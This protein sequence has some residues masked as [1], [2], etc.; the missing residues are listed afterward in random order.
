MVNTSED[1]V[2]SNSS[3]IIASLAVLKA[4]W[5]ELGHDYIENFLPF[6]AETIREAQSPQISLPDIQNTVVRRFGLRIPQGALKTILGRCVKR[7]FIKPQNRIY[8]RDG[9]ALESLSFVL[10]QADAVRKHTALED[11]FVNFCK[12]KYK[13]EWT[14]E[15]ANTAL[16]E[17]LQD[18]S[19]SILAAAIQGSP[20]VATTQ[21][22]KNSDFLVNSFIRHLSTDDP[23]GFAFLE[24][25]VKGSMLA[26]ALIF[27]EMGK[28]RRHFE[29][30]EVYFDTGF[31]LGAI[32][33][34]GS[35]RKESCGELLTLLY[36]QGAVLLIFEHTR[37][38][39]IGVLDAAGK[40]LRSGKKPAHLEF[41][42]YLADRDFRPS[43]IE[44]II[45]RIGESLRSLRIILRRRPEQ[46]HAYGLDETKLEATIDAEIRYRNERAKT[47]RY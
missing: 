28:I 24:T 22:V 37:D 26:N 21:F 31:I 33:L 41:F 30:V 25:V 5:D 15:I 19:P 43:D 45:A 18:R 11:K 39:V 3:R 46:K 27:P 38:E 12:E 17:Y 29:G 8:V 20:I 4:N 1:M 34:E 36:A 13:V 7:G 6:V 42:E 16:L 35:S 2:H 14:R 23:E 32:G 9:R 40:A 47:A 10:D 44:L